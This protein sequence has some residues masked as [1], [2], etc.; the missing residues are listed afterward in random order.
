MKNKSWL[1]LGGAGGI[2]VIG[3]LSFG[4][5]K[6][7]KPSTH[8]FL[9]HHLN[10]HTHH[11]NTPNSS[12]TQST[13][14]NVPI[15]TPIVDLTDIDKEKARIGWL[16]F[17]DANL[18]SNNRVS[19]ESCHS[20]ATNGAERTE[21]STGVW[22]KGT[23]NSITVFNVSYNYRFFWDGRANSLED[24]LDGPVHNVL[25]MDSNWERITDYISKS[26]RYSKLFVQ[27]GLDI[28]EANIKTTLIEFMRG[29]TTPKS[30]FDQ[31]LLGKRSALNEQEKRGWESFQEEGCI[32][33]HR[34]INIGGGMV[35]RFGYFGEDKT[36]NRRTD[37]TGR[38]NTTKREKDRYLFRVASLRNVADTAPYFHDG[39]TQSLHE[40]I[41]IMAESQLG[42]TF[43]QQT[44]DDLYAF[45]QTLSGQRPAILEEFSDEQ[46]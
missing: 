29:L 40:A 10:H 24:Q 41:Q 8:D 34:G 23:R 12:T 16:L 45:L 33:C 11:Q 46:K 1:I 7:L 13:A 39:K 32:Q 4:A 31:F 37:D 14:R 22:G 43:N 27:A 21:V 19:C 44:T 30:R 35:M 38:H 18:S 9:A 5:S 6:L 26:Q 36:G 17:K 28:T 25:E 42:K 3:V 20:L 15:I 2:L